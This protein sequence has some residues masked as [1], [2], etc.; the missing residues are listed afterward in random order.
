MEMPAFYLALE[1]MTPDTAPE[2]NDMAKPVKLQAVANAVVLRVSKASYRRATFGDQ[3]FL[4]D[5]IE[6][7]KYKPSTKLEVGWAVAIVFCG[8]FGTRL[9]TRGIALKYQT[10]G[11]EV[12]SDWS[13]DV[14]SDIATDTPFVR[15]T[16]KS[17]P[18]KVEASVAT[19]T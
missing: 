8:W 6:T 4:L 10:D 3:F 7:A 11:S 17:S 5:P 14:V 13:G 2:L 12:L 9:K 19:G 15:K 16:V 18:F 1:I